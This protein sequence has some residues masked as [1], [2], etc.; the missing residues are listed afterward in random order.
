[1]KN[2]NTRSGKITT[3][4]LH[5]RLCPLYL[6]LAG[7][8]SATADAATTPDNRQSKGPTMG[9]AAN[10]TPVVNIADPNAKGIS[11]NKFNEFNVEKQG[12]IFNNSM[13]DGVTKIGGYA[14][15]NAQLQHEAS[16]IIS[17][18]TGA[19]ASYINGTMEVFGKKADIIIANENGIS[20]NG[21]T[22]INANSLT[23]STGKVQA[24]NDGSY[25][26]AVEKGA[27]SVT[28]Q[29]I[30]TDGLG[31]F[32]IVSRSA[33]LEGEIAGKADIK[34]LAGQNDYDLATRSHTVR[35]KGDGRGPAVAIDGSALGSMYGGK[36]QLISTE[37]G[38]GVRHAGG[39]I[40][41]SDL[42]ISADGD[43]TL[44]SLSSEKNLSLSGKNITLNKSTSGVQ[45]KNDI[46]MNALAGITLNNDVIASTGKIRIDASSLV[47]N[48]ASLVTNNTTTT[49]VPAIQIN[50]AGQYTLNGKLQALDA[51]GKVIAGGVV[52]LKNS[53]F[54][55]K[56]N[57]AEVPFASLISDTQVTSHSGDVQITAGSMNNSGGSVLAKKGTL[58]FTLKEAFVNSGS[59]SAT[60]DL[61]IASG[62]LKNDGVLYA[63]NNQTLRVGNL[64]N[65]GRIF[66]EKRLVMNASALNNRGNIGATHDALQITT[67]GN[68]TNSGTLVGDAATVS[69]NVGGDVD[70]SGNIISNE[71][72]V[73]LAASGKSIKNQGKIEGKN[74]TL[75]ASNAD[76]TL[77]NSGTLNARQKAQVKAAKLN[78]NGGT[79]SA[80]GDIALNVSKQL[81]NTHGGAILA[82]ENLALDGAH[83]TALTNDNSRIQGEN[84]SLTNMATLSN[85]G[86]A[87]LLAN[88]AMDLSGATTLTNSASGI[89]ATSIL[90]DHIGTLTNT[91]DA[92]VYSSGNLTLSNIGTLTNDASQLVADGALAMLN[93][94][95]VSNTNSA[96]MVGSGSVTI[97][98]VHTLNNSN[99]AVIQSEHALSIKDVGTLNN[100]T[101]AAILASGNMTLDGVN[102]LNNASV[103]LSDGSITVQNGDTLHNNGVVQAG[104]D[105]I[106]RNI[107]RLVND[108]SD[109]VLMALRNLTIEDVDSL[110]NSHQAVITASMNTVLNA[111]GVLTNLSGGVIQ[112][113]DGALTVAANSLLNSG[114]EN[115]SNST[116]VAGGDVT[117]TSENVTNESGAAIVSTDNNLTLN[118][119]SNLNNSDEAVLA[120]AKTTSLN[121]QKGNIK[122]TTNAVIAGTNIA[123]ATKNLQ[124]DANASIT[125]DRDLQLTLA[126][127]NNTA[128]ILE[129]GRDL[130][131]SVDNSLT[132]DAN[133]QNIYAGR[134]MAITTHGDFTN[135]TQMEAIGDLTLNADGNF[136]NAMS[137]V[138]GGDL[139]V[140]AGN[141]TN[142]AGSLLWT[143]G[144]LSLDARNGNFFNGVSGNVLSMGDMSI[145]AKEI[146]NQAGIIR[147]EKD[148]NLDA[149][150]I[151]NE[152]S[153]T[154]DEISMTGYQ[155]ASAVYNTVEHLATKSKTLINFSMP[156]VTSGLKLDHQA[157]ISAGGNININQRNIFDRKQITNKGGLIQAAKDITVTGDIYNSPEYGEMSIYDYLQLPLETQGGITYQ[158]H[159]GAYHTSTW[160]FDTLYQFLDFEFGNGAAAGKSGSDDPE[161]G[162]WY[163]A[164]VMTGNES[165][166]FNK[167]M[168]DIFGE[169]WQTT[170]YGTMRNIWAS[171]TATNNEALKNNK[172]YFVPS[173]KGEITAGGNFTHKSG[174]LDNGIAGAGVVNSHSNVSDID[175]GEYTVDTVIAGYDV[176]VNTKKIDELAMGISPMPTIKDMV[177]IPGMFEVSTDFKKT[178]EA[179][180]NGTAYPGPAN[181]I[182][183]IFETRPSMIDQSAYTGSDY[184]FDQ[185]G[186]DPQKPVNVIGDNYFT[187]ELIRREISSSVGSFFAIRDGL[188]GDALVQALMDNAG[189]AA[190]DSELG[191]VVGQS[192]TEEQRNGLDSDIV[193]FVNQTVNGVDVMVPVVYLCPETL[194][195]MES[196]DVNGGTATIHAGGEMNVDADSINN[197][198][199]TISSK[200]DMTLVSD[201]DINN[202]SNGMSAGISA[203]GDI[204]MSSTSGN[205][206]NNGAAI[207]AE[208][209][210]NMSAAEGDITMTAS[211]GRDE[212]GKQVIHAFE[213][214]VTAGGSINMEAKSITSNASDITAGQDVSMKATDGD[215]TFND[216]HEIDATRIIDN[217]VRSALNFTMSDT[218]TTTGKAIGANVSAG[219]NMSIDAK[220]D[221]VMEGG[222]YNAQTG[223]ITAENDVTIKTSQDVAHEEQHSSSREFVISAGVS[224][225]GQSVNT[226][227]GTMDGGST[228]TTSGDYVSAGSESDTSAIGKK[229]GRAPVNDTAGFTFGMSTSSDS[230]VTDSKKN[231]NAAINFGQSGT[232]EAGK[233]V[234]IGGADLSA[235]DSL[236]INAEDVATTKYEDEMKNT[237]SHKETSFGIKG[238][239]HS[240]I[241][242][243]I[244]KAGNLI[245]K[246]TEGQSAN[247]GT[248]AAEVLGEASNLLLN[249]LAGGS[250]TIGGS[251]SK[252]H[253]TST[254]TAENINHINANNVSINTKKDTTLNGTDISGQ[255]VEI[256]AGGDVTMN[257]AKSTTSYSNTTEEHSA[258]ITAGVGVDL[259]GVSGGASVDYSGSKETGTGNST[260]YTNS[261]ITAGD[262]KIKSGGDMTMSGANIDANTADVDVAGDMT[263]NSLQD[264]VHTDNERANWGAS[265]GVAVSAKGVMPTGAVNGGGGSEAYDSATTAKQ[266]GIHTTGD[267]QVK[268]GGDLNMAGANIVSDNGTGEV[269]VAGNINAKDLQDTVEQDGLYGGG[270]VGIGGLPGK[271][272]GIP[273]ANIYV[274]TVDEIHRN[275]TQK[276]TISVG[277]TTSK[278]TTGE[279]NTNKDEMSVVTRDEKEAGNN[280]SYTLADP[281]IGKKKKGSYDVDT[282]NDNHIGGGSSKHSSDGTRKK[283]VTPAKPAHSE[284]VPAVTP[285]KADT[286]KPA[287]KP[288]DSTKKTDTTPSGTAHSE[289][290]PA[291]KPSKADD[292]KPAPKP[293]DSTTKT[294]T[295]PSETA[296][297]EEVPAVKPSKADDLK[298]AP[299]PADSTTKTDTTPSETAHSEEVPAV[300]PSKADDLKPAPK[301]ADSTT[302]KKKWDVP[303]TNYPTLSPGSAT[304]KTGKDMPK[305]PEHR[306][307][308]GDMTNGVTPSSNPKGTDVKLSPGSSTGQ[309][310]MDMPK[311]PEH[312]QWNGDMTNGV[313]PSSNPKGTDVKLSP[314]SSTGQTGMDMPK[315]PEH[316]QWNGDMT[317]GVAPSSNPKG[318]DV[319][320]SPGSSTGQT[321]MDMPKT[322]EHKQWNGD[323]TNGVAP[324]S[325]PKGTDVKL[326]P[327]SSTGQTGM[328]MPKT[329]EHKQWNGDMTNGVAPSSNPKGTDVKFSPGSS[330]GQTGMDMPKTPEHKQWNGDMTNG[331]APSSNPKGTDVKLSPG[332]STG[333]TGMD[334]PKTPEHKQWNG[335]MSAT[336]QPKQWLP[337]MTETPIDIYAKVTIAFQVEQL[338]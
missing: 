309:A 263:V 185:V 248:T 312:K 292:L 242:D 282:P 66:A 327:G 67:T 8:F 43:I 153:Y 87:V 126:S 9:Q 289:E 131:L 61:T 101:D 205:I 311:T 160:N 23:L 226:S 151:R 113:V 328:D 14:V 96:A 228:E 189:V 124:N 116:L 186:Y 176:Q 100:S 246:G 204:N 323:M 50:V 85:T 215:V 207:N 267:V 239:A 313:A 171:V 195:Q 254:S 295:T 105:L 317:N 38:A 152:S 169:T 280:I 119:A 62:S 245:E 192:L 92:T 137:I 158:W 268:T 16:A 298:P 174:K 223:S 37:S 194:R 305:T 269:N 170:D 238:E 316:K 336:A 95:N 114:S 63:S 133:N 276:S 288:A 49:T 12:M 111:V 57:G 72:D 159:L 74:V 256:N 71:K 200:G 310:G 89:Q 213:D 86:D 329:P 139:N 187:S 58:Q 73:T 32:D 70:N 291:V 6:S 52:T 197:A 117:V 241:V 25:K 285:S 331:V 128:G 191:L 44:A 206:N 15:K 110:T 236:T 123:V 273:S 264:T 75:T 143:M 306:K 265:V 224:G 293:A 156:I 244:D 237:S 297:S 21:A 27:V 271:K 59:V 129:A 82:G 307:W 11:M 281:G 180:K 250:V 76:A 19:K 208:G 251:S 299:K 167:M 64:D 40:A 304:G 134:A 173:E 333:Q 209:D 284:D 210:V 46:I 148:V 220:N 42:D 326:S 302:P 77:E 53:D 266:S 232:I 26:L 17:E 34:V 108:G 234:D 274:D 48:A 4:N 252:S 303:N 145:I 3:R 287:P 300:K 103:I 54:V 318:T 337:L 221:V 136:T 227:Y 201:G 334:M 278:G 181:N 18:V 10:G 214:G 222:T 1:M 41:S 135:S 115:G 314:G 138:T 182:V 229:P 335:D 56:V 212:S 60:G 308:N 39:I 78:N 144:D 259:S 188:E 104:T 84:I 322:P 94:T 102:T 218:S 249:D 277:G 83:T 183:P 130:S 296:H 106:I 290:V 175:V 93:I 20:V 45:A 97:D 272:G 225:G 55:V 235:G 98:T 121:V 35:N 154:G 79:L 233:T 255:N 168:S 51:N 65:N 68:V 31:Y 179:E 24:N 149:E 338:S 172:T 190:Q 294:D 2:K 7:I 47:Q 80:A 247:A 193:W 162:I 231:T 107:R 30:N 28:G 161:K 332:S 243:T 125:A 270:G 279:I 219:G 91:R 146:Y 81:N 319:K 286:L 315:T 147:A 109:H 118:V 13:Q 36:I 240:T 150:S 184:F 196:G 202:I 90:L 141:I 257:A 177:S 199:G 155:N 140:T 120:G 112:A 258:G 132:L 301:P 262:V 165:T 321:G 217:D 320:L 261:T 99:S 324:S 198:N 166:L 283:E 253:S 178:A 211:V 157:E 22:T 164:V 5:K 88:G 216:L 127:L 29:G 275:E 122:N 230:S 33:Q 325:N 203:G 69:L 163:N 330:T 260:S 142:N